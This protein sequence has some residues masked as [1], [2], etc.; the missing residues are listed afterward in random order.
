M[1]TF[2]SAIF[3]FLTE[4][5]HFDQML[6][7]R[8]HFDMVRNNLL[9]QFWK[10]VG[11]KLDEKIKNASEEWIVVRPKDI[12]Q[13]WS[14]ISIRM[15]SWK[16]KAEEEITP[17]RI[18]WE[19][20]TQDIHYGVWINNASKLWNVPG[21]KEAGKDIASKMRMDF[22]NHFWPVKKYHHFNFGNNEGLHNILPDVREDQAA[23]FAQ[24]LWNI[25][26]EH[27]AALSEMAL[28][29]NS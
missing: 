7:V 23:E 25:A 27:G 15:K 11:D 4:R 26:E 22:D 14:Q 6:K 20:L 17:V 1:D 21:M 18:A 2:D 12:H 13:R 29:R 9:D 8:S 19:S 5:D 16:P 28:M 24:L 3:E 10:L